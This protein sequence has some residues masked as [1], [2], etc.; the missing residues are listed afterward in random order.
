MSDSASVA[1]RFAVTHTGG[2][3]EWITNTAQVEHWFAGSEWYTDTAWVKTAPELEI[4]KA[5]EPLGSLHAGDLLTYTIE[6]EN[7]GESNAVGTS[8]S[9]TLPGGVDFSAWVRQNGTSLEG[10]RVISWYGSVRPVRRRRGS[11]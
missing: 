1:F 5:V 3:G 11:G 10:G 9:D 8:L 2:Y 4:R 6:I 7:S